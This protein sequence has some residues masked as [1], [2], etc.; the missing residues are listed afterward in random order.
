MHPYSEFVCEAY[1]FDPDTGVL[2]LH[3]GFDEEIRFEERIVFPRVGRT[4]SAAEGEAL[5]RV[6]RMLLLACG[7]S[8]YKA[9]APDRIRCAAFPVDPATAAFFTDFYVKGLGEFAWRNGLDLAGRLHVVTDAV[10]AASAVRVE[11]PRCTCVPVGGGKDSIVTVEC[12]K[13]AGE[14][15]VLFSLGNATPIDATIRQ[16]G[17]PFIRVTRTLDRR[18]MEL[19]AAGALNGHVPITGILSMIVLA[20]A[21]IVG[22]DAIAMSNEHSA[23]Q[24]TV[25]DV[26]HQYSKSFDFEQAVGRYIEAHVVKGITYFSFLRPLTEV[27]IASRF[28]RQTAYL[29][30]FMSC[31]TAFRQA[32]E[33]RSTNWCCDCPKCRFVFL[34]LAPFVDKARLVATF[35]RDMLDDPS[36]I[37]GFAELCGLRAHKPFECVGEIEESATTLRHLQEMAAWRD[38]AVVRALS[39]Q[40]RGGDFA[41]LFALRGP[42][43]V[44]ERYLAMLDACG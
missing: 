35:G 44:P 10:E 27:A 43:L 9:Y 28:A 23:S 37:D 31:N 17:L 39:P 36:Q 24:P 38:A 29:P 21:I 5:E 19:N 34:A 26:N 14:P 2:S 1:R 8:Y 3:Y 41:A 25:A 7:V 18:L 11:L 20:C 15:L 22:F 6:F 33:R 12:L 13:Q 30:V 40:V 16:S 4:L 42:H 32:P